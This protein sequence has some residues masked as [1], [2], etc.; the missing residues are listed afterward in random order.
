MGKKKGRSPDEIVM[1]KSPLHATDAC[2]RANICGST[3]LLV[4]MLGEKA[5]RAYLF[6]PQEAEG[7][8]YSI[9]IRN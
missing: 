7:F 5:A 4:P 1:T 2:A 8:R 6:D 3:R 9:G